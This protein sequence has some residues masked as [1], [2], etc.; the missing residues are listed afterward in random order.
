MFRR[1]PGFLRQKLL[2][3]ITAVHTEV[4][5]FAF[6]LLANQNKHANEVLNV[7]IDNNRAHG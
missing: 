7:C 3:F 1:P 5:V 6:L 2:S 4:L